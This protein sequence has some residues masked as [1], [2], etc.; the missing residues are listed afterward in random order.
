MSLVW[1]ADGNPKPE[2]QCNDSLAENVRAS[3]VGRQKIITITGA[4]S[5]NAG[6]Y[7]CV[8]TN[9]VGKVT[10]S[11]TLLLKGIIL[12]KKKLSNIANVTKDEKKI[13]Q[14]DAS[15]CFSYFIFSS[16]ADKST[17]LSQHWWVFLLVLLVFVIY[18]VLVFILKCPKKHG[19][20]NF[21]LQARFTV[22]NG[23]T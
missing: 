8:A 3:T 14:R 6:R 4:T 21:P 16:F 7:I 19:R 15:Y 9:K 18:L 5:T 1:E 22:E 20:Y 11:T 10:R 23:T 13:I 2:I 12:C 17:D